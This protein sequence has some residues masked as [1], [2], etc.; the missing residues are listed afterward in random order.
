[1]ANEMEYAVIV[2]ATGDFGQ[3]IVRAVAARG[4]AIVAVGRTAESL[5]SLVR[6]VPGV[7]PCIA[8]IADDSAIAAIAAAVT[9]P[10]RLAVH[11]PGLSAPGGVG[12]IAPGALAD[13]VNIKAGGM[14]RLVRGVDARLVDG[15]RLV[16]IAGHYGL[17]PTAYA[18]SAGVANAALINLSRQLSLEYGPR[19]VTAHVIAPGPADTARLRR[20]VANAAARRGVDTETVL[21]EIREQ[22][23]IG[24]MVTPEQVA[25][26]VALLLDPEASAMTGS[27]LM[28]DGGRRRGLP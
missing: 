14:L 17:E 5:K 1:M 25:W 3:A 9:G 13:S 15:S 6:D 2:G 12:E 23:S 21:E 24:G 10:V 27:T 4:L 22:S 20:V 16:A 8:D 26:S 7:T 11:G 19:G 18:A 28:L